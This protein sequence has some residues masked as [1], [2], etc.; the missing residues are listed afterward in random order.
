MQDEPHLQVTAEGGVDSTGQGVG[1][2][3]FEKHDGGAGQGAYGEYE[4]SGAR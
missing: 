1:L 3:C 4:L 2:Y